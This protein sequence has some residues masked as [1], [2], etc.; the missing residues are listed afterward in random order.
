MLMAPIT[1]V[2]TPMLAPGT[3]APREMKKALTSPE[4]ALPATA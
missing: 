2:T 3:S 1:I 4:K